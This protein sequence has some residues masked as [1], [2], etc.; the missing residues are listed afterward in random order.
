MSPLLSAVPGIQVP[1]VRVSESEG[2]AV[3]CIDLAKQ[4]EN[5]IIFQY[6]TSVISAMGT[7]MH[8]LH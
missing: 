5:P 7:L 8:H 1:D 4:I 6:T 3:V 2:I